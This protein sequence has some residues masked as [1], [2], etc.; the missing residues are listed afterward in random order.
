MPE[1]SRAAGPRILESDEPEMRY[2]R[3]AMREGSLGTD[4]FP[5]CYEKGIAA[6]GHPPDLREE[7]TRT[8]LEQAEL[9]CADWAA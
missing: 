6:I 3:M 9:L 1:E 5:D 4:R 7:A 2:W 8:V